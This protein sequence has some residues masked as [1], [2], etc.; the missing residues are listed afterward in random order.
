[1]LPRVEP[2]K[3]AIVRDVFNHSNWVYELKY[4]GFRALN[5]VSRGKSWMVSKKGFTYK[6]FTYKRFDDL[7]HHVASALPTREAIFDG[8]IV[9]VD[10]QGRP[11][12]YDL[13]FRRVTPCFAAF[14]IFFHE[15]KDV[16][17]LPLLKR[18]ALLRK[19]IPNQD[20]HLLYVDHTDDGQNLFELICEMDLEGVVMKQKASKY[21][22]AWI[23][24]KNPAYSQIQK[25]HE[26]FNR[27]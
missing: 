23:K 22:E 21:G 12:F 18:K 16:R 5:H 11:R 3:L 2:A 7:C 24:V 26:L 14:D 20:P 19:L 8:E 13:M 15:G 27:K 1:M 17:S 25:R 10:G 9:C 6:R 4:D